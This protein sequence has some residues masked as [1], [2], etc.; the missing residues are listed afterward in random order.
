MAI[1]YHYTSWRNWEIIQ[2]KGLSPYEIDKPELLEFFDYC[3]MAIWVWDEPLTPHSELGT[4]IHQLSAKSSTKIVK[5][6]VTYDSADILY[7]EDPVWG[8]RRVTLSHQ[9][10]VGNW[11]YHADRP[12]GILILKPVPVEQLELLRVFDLLDIVK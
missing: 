10:V 8:K 9:G 1:G 12:N 6:E 11:Q 4:I 3:P 7:Y 5:L 2:K